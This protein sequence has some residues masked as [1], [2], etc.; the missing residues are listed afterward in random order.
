MRRP[1]RRPMRRA[2]S[3]R[4]TAVPLLRTLLKW[5][6]PTMLPR[7]QSRR[8]LALG[9]RTREVV[10]PWFFLLDDSATRVGYWRRGNSGWHQ[11]QLLERRYQTSQVRCSSVPKL[12]RLEG[13]G[14][15]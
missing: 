11:I 4:K 1:Y 14:E 2:R 3:L 9:P 10:L 15:W 5:L 7:Q 12:G 6:I 13:V 8:Q